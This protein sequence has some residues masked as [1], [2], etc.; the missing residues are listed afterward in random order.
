MRYFLGLGS[1]IHPQANLPAM[2]RALFDLAPALHVG[3]V[4]QTAPVGVAG[5]PFLNVPVALACDLAPQELKQ[6]CNQLEAR[7]GRDRSDPQSKTKSRTADLDILFW[8][9][10]DAAQVPAELLPPE[11]Y[12][13]PMLLELLGYLGLRSPAEPPALAPGVPLQL[14]GRAF[15]VAPLTLWRAS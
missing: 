11:P 15:G 4:L 9:A 13:R 7:L 14:D 2:L 5:E 1:N 12:M 6:F 3:R 10:P 8:L